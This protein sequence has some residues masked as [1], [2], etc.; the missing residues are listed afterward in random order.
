MDTHPKILK[1][2][3]KMDKYVLIENTEMVLQ[4]QYTGI[5]LLEFIVLVLGF[6]ISLKI[7]TIREGNL[8]FSKIWGLRFSKQ[9]LTSYNL[10]F[11]KRL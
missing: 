7:S 10:S 6:N 11:F 1:C 4:R 5:M 8:G 3:K 2:F 9:K